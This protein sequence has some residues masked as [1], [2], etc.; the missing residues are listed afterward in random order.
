MAR[1]YETKLPRYK[2]ANRRGVWT[3][4]SAPH[5][6][7]SCL[8]RADPLQERLLQCPCISNVADVTASVKE[9]RF[10]LDDHCSL[11]VLTPY[12]PWATLVERG[13]YNERHDTLEQE[14]AGEALRT[15]ASKGNGVVY[16]WHSIAGERVLDFRTDGLGWP[17]PPE[18]ADYVDDDDEL[19][20]VYVFETDRYKPDWPQTFARVEEAHQQLVIDL[21]AYVPLLTFDGSLG[22][23]YGHDDACQS[24]HITQILLIEFATS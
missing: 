13:G 9:G 10:T 14:L 12:Q 17:A 8:I 1:L 2:V 22:A 7:T 3:T 20:S 23:E 11:L 21:D 4:W 24:E 19:G 15:G 16:V 5:T 6:W 18:D